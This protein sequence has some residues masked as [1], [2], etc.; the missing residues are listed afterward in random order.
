LNR[1]AQ[2]LHLLTNSSLGLP[3]D[4]WLPST[5][6]VQPEESYQAAISYNKKLDH[7][8]ELSL[9]QYYKTFKNVIEYKEGAN[10]L[11]GIDQNWED[12]ITTGKGES[13]GIE[14]LLNKKKGILTGWIA[15]TLSNTSRTFDDL[16]EGKSFPYQYDRRH[17]VSILSTFSVSSRKSFTAI[18][19]LNSGNKV[20][21]PVGGYQGLV[22][23]GYTYTNR[24]QSGYVNDFVNQQIISER[25]NF[26][27]PVYHRM[28]I[29]Y[30]TSKVTRKNNVR[31]WAFSIYNVYNRHN[32]FAIYPTSDGKIKKLTLFPILPSVSYKLEF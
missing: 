13:Y 20:T 24:Y 27:M 30:Q 1:N 26:Q 10:Y 19:V 5:N 14:F 6:E 18:F 15:Y 8:L 3:T 28:D 22:P 32:A 4:L 11:F 12:K 29:N 21:I 9:E 16:N 23:P 25:N 31:T 17:D 7:N 2:F